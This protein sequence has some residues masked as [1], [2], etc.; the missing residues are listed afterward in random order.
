MG[1]MHT[2]INYLMH[3]LNIRLRCIQ[4]HRTPTNNA[5]IEII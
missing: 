2:F 5:K 4:K 3:V 1:S